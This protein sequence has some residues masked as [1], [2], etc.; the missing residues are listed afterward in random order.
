MGCRASPFTSPSWLAATLLLAFAS[1]TARAQDDLPPGEAA[2]AGDWVAYANL[3]L[4][5]ADGEPSWL[6]GGFGKARFGGHAV[7]RDDGFAIRPQATEFGLAWQPHLT[8][9]L[10]ATVAAIAQEGQQHAIDLSQA[11]LTFKPMPAG[12]VRLSARAG[13]FW[14]PVSLEHSG[15][16]WAVRDTITPSAI[17][18]W[19]GEEVK[20]AG[21]EGTATGLLGSHRLTASLA[22]FADNDTAGT[23][24]AFRGW[25]LHDEK[26]TAFGMQ[27]LPA[28]NPFM[29]FVQATRT[30]PLIELDGRPGY[31]I[32]LAWAPPGPFEL[33]A[34][35]YDNRGDP[36]V[37]DEYFQWGWRTRFDHLGVI[38]DVDPRTRLIAQGIDGRTQMGFVE[39]NR[40]WVDTRFRSAF[41]L[42]TRAMDDGSVSARIEAFGT[43]SRGS[44]LGPRDSEKGW[45]VTA[46]ARKPLASFATIGVEALHVVSRRD[47]RARDALDPRQHQTIV[48]LEL[49]LR[50]VR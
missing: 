5:G 17:N 28:L 27:P 33:Q 43:R 40:R 35:H 24:L 37:V 10:G 19:I 13:L 1:N 45:A 3:D 2:Q 44:E 50:V 38:V 16:E 47:A 42:A 30:R 8:W 7:D 26:A 6:R 23:L 22:L 21:V 15:P 20:L 48:R 12:P 49:R 14:A 34:L 39:G 41:L 9:S 32:K 31:Y 11:Y 25:A 29:Q 36:E 46:A 18:T 4:E